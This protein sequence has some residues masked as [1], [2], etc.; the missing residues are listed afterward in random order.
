MFKCLA[1]YSQ[2]D[3]G[4]LDFNASVLVNTIVQHNI[5]NVSSILLFSFRNQFNSC[6]IHTRET[7]NHHHSD[8]KRAPLLLPLLS[9]HHPLHLGI[10]E[11]LIPL[12]HNSPSTIV[13][14]DPILYELC[15]Y[16]SCYG[17]YIQV[18]FLF[19]QSSFCFKKFS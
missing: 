9:V 6:V 17:R 18:L 15:N 7:Q 8:H 11:L 10:F 14:G 5:N 3:N 1:K 13:I 19:F 2:S 4:F 12:F 16:F